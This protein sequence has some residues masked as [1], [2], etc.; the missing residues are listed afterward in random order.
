M[1][2]GGSQLYSKGR[3]TVHIA[4]RVIALGRLKVNEGLQ[5]KVG[6]VTAEGR[7]LVYIRVRV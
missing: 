6:K 5:L 7:R 1:I 4:G 2:S 3:V